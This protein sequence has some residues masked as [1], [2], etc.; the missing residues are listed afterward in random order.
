MAQL[1]S[2]H[3]QQV[4]NQVRLVRL[5]RI[6]EESRTR[7]SLEEAQKVAVK[8][9]DHYKG[10]LADGWNGWEKAWLGLTIGA[11]GLETAG[12]VLNLLASPMSLIPNITAGASG[13][14]GS[15]HVTLSV[16]GKQASDALG[17]TADALKGL[18]GIA[19]MGAGMTNT[20]GSY[21]RRAQ[22][23]KLQL[24]LAEQEIVQADRQIAAARV[25]VRI[26]ENELVEH[27]KRIEHAAGEDEFLRTKFTNRELHDWTVTQL[28]ALHFQSYRL[29]HD[30]A[31]RA[32]RCFRYELGL[33]ASDYIRF[34]SWDSLRKGLLS[35]ERLAHDLRR[36]ETAYQEQNR[37]EYELTKHVSL[38]Q[39]DPVALLRLRQNG[40]CFVD[41]PESAFDLDYPGHYFRRLKT[42]GL[43]VPCVTGPATTVAC[44][45]TL[46]GN[47]LRKDA[48]LLAG[49]YA[50]DTAGEDPRFRD[51]IGAVQLIATST[52][53]EDQGLFELSF[54]DERYLPF[55]GAGAVSSWHLR[56]GKDLPQFDF[57]SISDVVLHLRYT[58]REGGAV[59][60]TQAATELRRGL[61]E[62]ALAESRRG[63][64]RV[65]DLRREFPDAWY[66][67]L[68]PSGTGDDQ[69]L[70]LGDLTARLPFFT[71]GFTSHKARG[72][73]IVVHPADPA[74]RYE[75]QL[76]PLGT[77][78]E[79]LLPI[80]P[81]PMFEGLHRGTRDLT[82]TE[83]DLDD[84]WTLRL[85]RAGATDFRSLAVDEVTEAF[86]IISYT[87]A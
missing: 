31:R 5:A 25:R 70:D 41:I 74:R 87:V 78:P 34:G 56:L 76:S 37:R 67:F 71:R 75:A 80:G 65:L 83:A 46:T 39:L 24:D 12:T 60:R 82:G 44:T 81:D 14:G 72:V 13:F 26:A 66:R 42:V 40:E 54:R 29:A 4:L 19:Q 43:T 57:A 77:E 10:L 53:Q 33:A 36:L 64:Y 22:D 51:E 68:R 49:K 1:R 17:K 48:T 30:M 79:D 84:T 38:A 3:E 86:L 62:T 50:R 7:E 6:E 2:T 59:L 18:S 47:R 63:L 61:G 16:S 28:S 8:R 52:A 85:R 15:P 58:A 69:R 55:E 11:M 45:L 32:E 27:D 35:G 9:R 23:W 20:I 73:E 21:E